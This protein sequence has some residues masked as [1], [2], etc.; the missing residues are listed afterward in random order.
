VA[1]HK[2]QGV[3]MGGAPCAV[4]IHHFGHRHRGQPLSF[5]GFIIRFPVRFVN[6]FFVNKL[7]QF[8]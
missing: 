3:N 8:C 4:G 5:Y 1:F 7:L 2:A 6:D